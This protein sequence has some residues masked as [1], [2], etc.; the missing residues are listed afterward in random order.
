MA[1][2]MTTIAA[3]MT[4]LSEMSPGRRDVVVVMM[5]FAWCAPARIG[6]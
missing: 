1:A 5:P 3:A 4:A 6:P 2:F